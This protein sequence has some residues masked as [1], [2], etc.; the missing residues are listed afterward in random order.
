MCSDSSIW[1]YVMVKGRALDRAKLSGRVQPV[2]NSHGSGLIR[3][4]LRPIGFPKIFDQ[5]LIRQ[6]SSL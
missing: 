2:D 1:L 5:D 4:G 6:N 3:G